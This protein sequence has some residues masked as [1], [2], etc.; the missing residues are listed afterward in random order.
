MQWWWTTT[1]AKGCQLFFAWLTTWT[2]S[3]TLVKNQFITSFHF[4]WGRNYHTDFCMLQQFLLVL[5][6]LC[7]LKTVRIR[8][9]ERQSLIKTY[10]GQCYAILVLPVVINLCLHYDFCLYCILLFGA[11]K[12]TIYSW[13]TKVTI[14]WT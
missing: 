3:I 13:L 10:F 2:I 8:I 1:R 5:A 4:C 14:I 9:V 6:D 11:F 7:S 12:I